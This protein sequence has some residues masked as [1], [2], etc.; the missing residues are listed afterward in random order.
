MAAARLVPRRR[1]DFRLSTLQ[2][3]TTCVR[4]F[5]NSNNSIDEAAINELY[6]KKEVEM[7]THTD[8]FVSPL[9]MSDC[10]SL[11]TIGPSLD[12]GNK[13]INPSS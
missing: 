9:S 5:I 11:S 12:T 2:S 4:A 10:H 7:Y 3:K 1:N 13:G 8:L 6:L